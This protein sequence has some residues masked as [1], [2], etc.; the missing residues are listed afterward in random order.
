MKMGMMAQSHN[1]N[2]VVG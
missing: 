2:A 1:D